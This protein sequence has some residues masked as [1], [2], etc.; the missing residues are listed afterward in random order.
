MLPKQPCLCV[1]VCVGVYPPSDVLRSAPAA[2]SLTTLYSSVLYNILRR[3]TVVILY[4]LYLY[5]HNYRMKESITIYS[6]RQLVVDRKC[7]KFTFS[8]HTSNKQ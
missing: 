3:N 2:N 5:E 8:S 4:K 7:L 1:R 6:S